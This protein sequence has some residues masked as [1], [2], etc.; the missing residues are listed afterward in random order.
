MSPF[1]LIAFSKIVIHSGL[2]GRK[3]VSIP[4][5]ILRPAQQSHLGS[6]KPLIKPG[7]ETL[8]LRNVTCTALSCNVERNAALYIHNFCPNVNGT[9]PRNSTEQLSDAAIK[10][11]IFSISKMQWEIC[12]FFHFLKKN[13]T[14]WHRLFVVFDDHLDKLYDFSYW[15]SQLHSNLHIFLNAAWKC[16]RHQIKRTANTAAYEL[17]Q[18]YSWI[19]SW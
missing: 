2:S 8:G 6:R 3:A 16:F 9:E 4:L 12:F 19:T 7:M 5:L 18:I 17:A 15:A 14:Q 13:Q 1:V 10:S 11:F